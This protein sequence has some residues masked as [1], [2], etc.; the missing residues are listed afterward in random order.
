MYQGQHGGDCD[1]CEEY[2]LER[3]EGAIHTSHIVTMSL[4][5]HTTLCVQIGGKSLIACERVLR[6]GQSSVGWYE[7]F[8]H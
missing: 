6:R 5:V 4:E 1:E 2:P 8:T 3:S 7:Y